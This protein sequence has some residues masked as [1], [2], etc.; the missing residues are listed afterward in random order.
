MK[1]RVMI[2][3]QKPNLTLSHTKVLKLNTMINHVVYTLASHRGLSINCHIVVR[4]DDTC[5]ES[6]PSQFSF[7][8]KFQE[9]NA[10][11]QNCKIELTHPLL[12]GELCLR[13]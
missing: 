10:Y 2:D 13:C 12:E 7:F 8:S 5:A 6:G 1:V 4:N 9:R 3:Q 11:F